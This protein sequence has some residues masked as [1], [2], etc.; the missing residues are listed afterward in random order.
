MRLIAATR[1]I[2]T[3]VTQLSSWCSFCLLLL[4]KHKHFNWKH[5][6]HFIHAE[7]KFKMPNQIKVHS[8]IES[9]IS[10]MNLMHS[11]RLQSIFILFNWSAPLTV[12]GNIALVDA[13]I[14][15]LS[16]YGA[17]WVA[18]VEL[19][20]WLLSHRFR[21]RILSYLELTPVVAIPLHIFLLSKF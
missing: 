18:N 15:S 6:W 17:R 19:E 13:L 5:F 3:I 20:N 7:P 14:V 16:L 21:A 9:S 11:W 12:N 1:L 8:M 4:M 10:L 2:L